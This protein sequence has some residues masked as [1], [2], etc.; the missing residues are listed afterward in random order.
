MLINAIEHGN[1][2]I[3]YEKK[4]KLLSTGINYIE[5]LDNLCNTSPYMDRK[6]EIS[7]HFEKKSL[8]FFIKDEGKGFDPAKVPDPTQPENLLKDSG[9]GLYLMRIYMDDL[10]YNMTPTGTETILTLKTK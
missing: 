8:S 4:R 6:V 5:Y 1:L 9:R 2:E 3:D 7:Y 10:K